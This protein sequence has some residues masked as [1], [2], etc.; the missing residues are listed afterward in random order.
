MCSHFKIL[1]NESGNEAYF[2]RT[3]KEYK[4][5]QYFIECVCWKFVPSG[6]SN[7]KTSLKWVPP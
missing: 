6:F 1:F 4:L 7:N 2:F 5:M 3:L